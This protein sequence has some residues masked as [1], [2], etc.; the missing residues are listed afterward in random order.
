MTYRNFSAARWVVLYVLHR[1]R[2]IAMIEHTYDSFLSSIL[3]P[4]SVIADTARSDVPHI[5]PPRS[6][7]FVRY[8]GQ[9][10]RQ[11]WRALQHAVDQSSRLPM[12]S[13]AGDSHLGSRFR[14]LREQ[15]GLSLRRLAELSNISTS[16]L[17]ELES[18]ARPNP[19][20]V[21]LL[22]L[23]RVYGF[24]SIEALLGDTPSSQWSQ[25]Y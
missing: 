18:E 10:P 16:R 13:P 22:S 24:D 3:C 6:L 7:G 14:D 15:R 19:T 21:V 1:D 8:T 4:T 5:R 12:T 20:L 9:Y 2:H 11:S 17:G 23:M 25:L